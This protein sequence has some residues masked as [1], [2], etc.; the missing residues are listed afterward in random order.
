MSRIFRAA[1]VVML[2]FLLAKVTALVRQQVIARSIGASSEADAYFAAFTAPDLIFMLIS[3]GALATAFIPVFSEYLSSADEQRAAAWRMASNVLT[4]S[5]LLSALVA[6]IAAIAAPLFVPAVIVPGFSPE[7]QALT[8][9]LMRIILL[10]TVIFSISGLVTGVLHTMQH[11][12]MPSFAPAI[13]NVGI[14]LGAIFLVPSMGIMG[15]AWGS[16]IGALFHLGVQIPV[17][18]MRRTHLR[19]VFDL[20]DPGLRQVAL[21]M[22]PRAA[23]LGLIYSKFIVRT[24][25]ASRL[26][27]GNVSALDYAWDLMQLPETLFATAVATA[28]FPTLAEL[29]GPEKRQQLADTFNYALRMIL[30]LTVPAAIGMLL[31]SL[32]IVRVFYE[33]GEF[34]LDASLTTA[35]ALNFFAFGIVGH[36]ILEVVARLYYARKDTVRPLIAA[37]IMLVVTLAVAWLSL[38]TLGVAGIALADTVGV[39]VESAVLMWWLRDRLPEALSRLTQVSTLKVVA[40]SA[41]MGATILLWLQFIGERNLFIVAG[42]G[43]LI[44]A[45]VYGGVALLLGIEEIKQMPRLML[46]RA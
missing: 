15:L 4:V 9:E 32:P 20:R 42:G 8:V 7:N 39:F 3:G 6:L 43:I 30:T 34:T 38:D 11:F 23:A 10:S 33:R 22:A 41:A 2:G 13:Y 36:G 27:E 24:N 1:V 46:R 35:A 25:L 12:L 5:L 17:L 44:G 28:V 45:A 14:I 21:L 26:G 29:A 31:L 37:A 16:V 19:P 18:F 40:A